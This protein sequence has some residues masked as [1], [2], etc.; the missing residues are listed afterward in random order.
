MDKNKQ[1]L[2]RVGTFKTWGRVGPHERKKAWFNTHYT[3]E[4]V[5]YPNYRSTQFPANTRKVNRAGTLY[6]TRDVHI[7][8]PP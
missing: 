6:H 2:E 4:H 7:D 5:K 8:S 3:Y 1:P